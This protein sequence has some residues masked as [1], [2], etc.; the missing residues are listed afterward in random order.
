MGCIDVLSSKTI[1][2]K[3]T[4]DDLKKY[5]SENWKGLKDI[6]SSQNIFLLS[7]TGSSDCMNK[8]NI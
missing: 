6:Q 5:F 3:F 4:I 8:I 7:E 1:A 2:L